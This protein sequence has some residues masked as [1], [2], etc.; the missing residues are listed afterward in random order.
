[1][2]LYLIRHGR[3]S[4]RLCNVNVDLDENGH[5][6][7][8][9]VGER[10]LPT[11]IDVVY[12]SDLYRAVQTAEEANRLWQVR[13]VIDARLRE[14]SYGDMEGMS[15][16][17]IAVTYAGLNAR[18]NL[19]IEDIPYPG[20]ECAGDV[21]KRVM[22]VL[23]E[24]VQT[25]ARQVAIVT[26]GGV[27]RSIVTYLLG[28]ELAKSRLLCTS[29]ENCSITQLSWNPKKHRFVLERLNDFAHLEPY[30]HLLRKN[31]SE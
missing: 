15:D 19:M 22:P 2:N 17:D 25:D 13:H 8:R 5:R 11:E 10:L 14:I 3:Q 28:M 12:S 29:L 30:P 24:I 9:L 23:E 26:H 31:W 20:G 4:S 18:R 16:E 21:V 27:I 7:A 1:M 6:Q